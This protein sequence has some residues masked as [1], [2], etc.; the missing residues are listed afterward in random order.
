MYTGDARFRS[1]IL[2]QVPLENLTCYTTLQLEIHMTLLI[3]KYK[4][5][6]RHLI[7]KNILVLSEYENSTY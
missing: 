1:I 6:I 4:M 2:L 7:K 3:Q 5:G